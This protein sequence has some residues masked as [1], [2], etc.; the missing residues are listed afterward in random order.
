MPR[1]LLLPWLLLGC[2][3]LAA[4]QDDLVIPPVTIE[5][6]SAPHRQSEQRPLQGGTLPCRF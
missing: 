6:L 3:S 5:P 4:A 2:A 1:R